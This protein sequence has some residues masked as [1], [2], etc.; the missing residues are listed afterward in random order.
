VYVFEWLCGC[1][2]YVIMCKQKRRSE[3]TMSSRTDA[4]KRTRIEYN[5]ITLSSHKEREG[6][7][8][9]SSASSLLMYQH[10]SIFI[11]VP[12]TSIN[13][14]LSIAFVPSFCKA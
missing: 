13:F 8:L 4:T 6:T 12:F 11:P 10:S 2:D 1:L 9:T 3:Y 14:F 7:I 5:S